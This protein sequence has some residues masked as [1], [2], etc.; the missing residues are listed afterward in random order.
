M[1]CWKIE[2]YS[3]VIKTYA[4]LNQSSQILIKD[5]LYNKVLKLEDPRLLGKPL[6]YKLKGFWRYRINKFRIIC[7]FD[8][9]NYLILIASINTRD[10]IYK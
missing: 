6:K 4:K 7:K 10:K 8:E 9:V 2:F 5:Y 3:E 1:A